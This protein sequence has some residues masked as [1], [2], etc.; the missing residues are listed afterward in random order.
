MGCSVSATVGIY[1]LYFCPYSQDNWKINICIKVHTADNQQGRFS[2]KADFHS[3]VWKLTYTY[4]CGSP[5]DSQERGVCQQGFNGPFV[6][7][8]LM[9]WTTSHALVIKISIQK[10]GSQ[11]HSQPSV[12]VYKTPWAAASSIPGIS[13]ATLLGRWRALE[14]CLIKQDK[15]I[16][17]RM[18]R[19][20]RAVPDGESSP[21]SQSKLCTWD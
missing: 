7:E 3:I 16:K 8:V 6:L 19:K 5:T 14:C 15:Q 2:V 1:S 17:S 21:W 10:T 18:P 20:T 12:Q 9:R 11:R 4:K 13:S